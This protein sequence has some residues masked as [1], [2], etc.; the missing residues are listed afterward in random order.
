MT[1]RIIGQEINAKCISLDH[2]IKRILLI[3][4][5]KVSHRLIIIILN[6]VVVVMNQILASEA[7][8]QLFNKAGNARKL[9]NRAEAE[10]S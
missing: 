3:N 4:V 10:L 6:V 1:K 8:F 5:P 9:H 2:M 7:L